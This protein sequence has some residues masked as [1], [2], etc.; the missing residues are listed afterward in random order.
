[1]KKDN[2]YDHKYAGEEYYWGKKP[3]YL[4]DKVLEIIQPT[5][6]YRPRLLDLGCG[7][8]KDAVY[9]AQHGFNVVGVDVS[10]PGLQK[11]ER[12]AKE[13][14]ISVKTIQA[15]LL[16]YKIDDTYD[17]IFS[18]GT[19]HY[20]PPEIRSKRFENYKNCTS[21]DGINV[22][23]L[24]VEKP[25][26]PRAPDGELTAYHYRSGELFGYYWDW[27]ILYCIEQIWDCMS[28]GIPHK[29]ASNRM[30]AKKV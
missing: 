13:V 24:F 27:E 18:T 16:N 5:E 10:L 20:L 28:G 29:H 7:E 4:C 17:V 22:F 26:I 23:S 12:Y 14:G 21:Q 11:T 6:S 3:S 8:G 9:F 2:P 25:F 30:I 1:M 19:L 15:D